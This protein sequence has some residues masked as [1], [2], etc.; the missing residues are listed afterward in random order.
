MKIPIIIHCIF[1]RVSSLDG[2]RSDVRILD[3]SRH[4]V[5]GLL[6][7]LIVVNVHRFRRLIWSR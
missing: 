2:L 1:E 7:E 3:R 6:V 5:L 4:R